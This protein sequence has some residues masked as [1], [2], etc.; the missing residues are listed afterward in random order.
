MK[1]K[2][3]RISS[4]AKVPTRAKASDAGYDLYAANSAV[5][6]P[7]SRVLVSTGIAIEI[8]EG[9]YGRI[10]PRSGLALRGGIDVLGG[11]V[12]SGY[13]DEIG[14]ILVNL[15]LPD[16]L[17]KHT[18]SSAEYSIMFGSKH[19]LSIQKG[20]RIAQIIIEKCHD[21]EFEEVEELPASERGEAGY[22]SSG[23]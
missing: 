1:I 21:I 14:V 2:I 6:D 23:S 4:D 11:V 13:R 22:G 7:M 5:L 3:K 18:K 20:D 15:N 9:Y 10:A 16:Y 12:D 17:H 8:P 19:R